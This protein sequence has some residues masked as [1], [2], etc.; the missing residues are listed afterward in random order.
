MEDRRIGM[1]QLHLGLTS[2]CAVG[3]GG[4]LLKEKKRQDSTRTYLRR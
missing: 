2:N 1:S 3:R 4:G